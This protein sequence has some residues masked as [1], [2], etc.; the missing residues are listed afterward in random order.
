MQGDSTVYVYEVTEEA[1]YLCPLSHHRMDSLHQGLS[2]LPKN[3]CNISGVEFA[4]A[5][6]LTN[7]TIKPVSYTVPRIKVSELLLKIITSP[8]IQLYFQSELFQDDLFPP[9]RVIWEV[10]L[11]ASEWFEGST[12]QPRRVSLKPEGMDCCEF[13]TN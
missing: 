11:E 10:T 5:L 4:K 12:K 7:N 1:P 9:T 2:F 8:K 13:R 6:R 3:V